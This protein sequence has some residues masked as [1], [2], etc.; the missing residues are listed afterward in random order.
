MNNLS[1][2]RESLDADASGPKKGRGC[3]PGLMIPS[4]DRALAPHLHSLPKTSY[5]E[6]SVPNYV[7]AIRTSMPAQVSFDLHVAIQALSEGPTRLLEDKGLTFTSSL[8]QAAVRRAIAGPIGDLPAILFCPDRPGRVDYLNID[9]VERTD[10]F[11]AWA[12]RD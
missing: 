12:E 9:P 4:T 2:A 5:V 3:P 6:Q 1:P 10:V 11:L 7:L 8:A